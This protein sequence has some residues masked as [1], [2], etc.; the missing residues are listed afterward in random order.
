VRNFQE[1]SRLLRSLRAVSRRLVGVKFQSRTL[2][3]RLGMPNAPL[4]TLLRS[5]NANE[6]GCGRPRRLRAAGSG[7]AGPVRLVAVLWCGRR[8]ACRPIGWRWRTAPGGRLGSRGSPAR[9]PNGSSRCGWAE[10]D[11]PLLAG[12]EVQ[13][14]QVG[15]RVA[16]Q[17]AGV[18]EVELLDA[19][20]AGNRPA[21]ILPSPP[22]ASRAA[23]SRCGRPPGIPHGPGFGAGPLG[24][25]ARELAQAAPRP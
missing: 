15:D 7:P 14:G 13:C 11:H 16:F 18:V 2:A 22:C 24:E 9:S 17:P 25:P 19:L 21:R 1:E 5:K 23:T 12:N 3:G 20:R 6:R 8:R 4:T 10:E